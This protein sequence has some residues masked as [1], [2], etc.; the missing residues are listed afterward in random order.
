MG[1]NALR[2]KRTALGLA[3]MALIWLSTTAQA[4]LHI[5]VYPSQDNTNQTLWI[6]RGG[7]ST[8]HYP[9]SIRSSG[10]YHARDSWQIDL[11]GGDFYTD[12]KPTN[13]FF[14]L[15]PLFGSTNAIDIESVQNRLPGGGYRTSS[16][17]ANE[18]NAPTIR[19]V[20]YGY[21]VVASRTI[22]K[23]FMN[24]TANHDEIG[25]RINPPNLVYSSN[26]VFQLIGAGIMDK[27]ISDFGISPLSGARDYTYA[28]GQPVWT[29][30]YGLTPEAPYFSSGSANIGVSRSFIPEPEQYALVFGLFALGF[31][32]FRHFRK[33]PSTKIDL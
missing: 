1:F 5:N 2:T 21:S 17:T 16:F 33:K 32:F 30:R 23:I 22:G 13:Q 7:F 27:P 31:V 12:N 24:D 26:S 19:I 14:N 10:N 25:I 11:A 28:G 3:G 15:T 18:T 20:G 4:Q 8:A 29:K 6:F 9:S